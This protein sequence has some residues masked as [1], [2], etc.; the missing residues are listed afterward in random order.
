MT[1]ELRGFSIRCFCRLCVRHRGLRLLFND[2]N[3]HWIV[4]VAQCSG[5]V[6]LSGCAGCNDI[7][8]LGYRQCYVIYAVFGP[9]D[10]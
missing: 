1:I 7:F 3:S 2:I 6:Q 4:V 5:D 8:G 10:F 9:H